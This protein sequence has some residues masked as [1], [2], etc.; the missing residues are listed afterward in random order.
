MCKGLALA[1]IAVICLS[2]AQARAQAQ[3]GDLALLIPDLFGPNGLTVN[4]RAVLPDG[5]T[6]S[7]HFNS[8]FQSEFGQFNVALGSQL[9][10]VPLPSPASGFTYE[11]DS[12]LGVFKRS[13]QSFGPLLAE[14]AETVGR[15]KLTFGFAYQQFHF[16]TIEGLDLKALPAVF[17]HDDSELGG[18]RSDIVTTMNSISTDIRRNVGFLTYGLTDRIDVAVA[19]P[20]VST[21][22]NLSSLAT[23]H[24]IGT[25]NPEVHFFEDV[26]G[27][28]GSDRQFSDSGRKNGVGDVIVRI[29]AAAPKVGTMGLAFAGEA[30]FPTGDANNFLGSGAWGLSGAVIGSWAV[31]K[32]SPHVDVAYHWNGNS[33]LAGDVKT[34]TK[35]SLPD[36]LS[37]TAGVDVGLSQTFTLAIDFL[38]QRIINSSRLVPTTFVAAN[39]QSFDNIAFTTGSFSMDNLA[40]GGKVNLGGRLL[41]DGSIIVKLDNPGL[42]DRVSQLIGFEYSF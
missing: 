14:R 7:A 37:Y 12:S 9:G 5:S 31:G 11:F 10:S 17:L 4:S 24:R 34:G 13:T 32:A 36:Q 30:R 19:V 27:Q 42:R 28:D 16:D 41:L 6:H 8:D 33:V 38:G 35:A 3:Q 40:L 2:A 29:K 18:G 20:L 21:E 22:M 39:G 26:N 1:V 15:G 23:I 25:S